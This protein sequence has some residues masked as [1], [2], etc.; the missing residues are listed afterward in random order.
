VST[1]L[2]PA[3]GGIVAMPALDPSSAPDHSELLAWHVIRLATAI[4]RAA[5]Q[6]FRRMFDMSM[7]EWLI[8]AHLAAEAPVSLT[9]LARNANLD[10][11]RTGLAVGNLAKRNLVSRARNPANAREAQVTLTPRGQA[12]FNAIIENWLDQELTHGFSAAELAVATGLL[13]RLAARADQILAAEL[14]NNRL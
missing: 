11:Q 2:L 10:T 7:I 9:A 6:R 3:R 14:K 8:V 1:N 5:T 4:R 13:N 12:V